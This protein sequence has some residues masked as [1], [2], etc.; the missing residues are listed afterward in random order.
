MGSFCDFCGKVIEN[1]S[2]YV[3]SNFTLTTDNKE[4]K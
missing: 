2:K 3:T 4:Q 1:Q